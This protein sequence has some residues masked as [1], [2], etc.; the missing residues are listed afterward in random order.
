MEWKPF[1]ALAILALGGVLIVRRWEVRL[2][3]AAVA[4]G[5]HVAAGKVPDFFATLFKEMANPKTILPI[6]SAMGFAYVLK[7][8]ECDRHLVE[9]LVGPLRRVR[10]LLVPGGIAA[11]FIVN[12]AIQSQTGTAAVVGPIL[13]PLLLAGRVKPLTAGAVLLLGSSMGGEL[14]NPG[15][16]EII[17]LANLDQVAQSAVKVV[18]SG[19]LPLNL[20]AC[21]V[22]ALVAWGVAIW[23]DSLIGRRTNGPTPAVAVAAG[24]GPGADAPPRPASESAYPDDPPEPVKALDHTLEYAAAAAG[25]AATGAAAGPFRL[26]VFKALI[27]LLP[28]VLLVAQFIL[29]LP[30]F[31]QTWLGRQAAYPQ[32]IADA[33]NTNFV[34]KA[35]GGAKPPAAPSAPAALPKVMDPTTAATGTAL[36]VG[37]FVAALTSPRRAKRAAVAFF[38]GA[39]FAYNHVV[40]LII[41]ATAVSDGIIQNGLIK[42]AADGLGKHPAGIAALSVLLPWSLATVTGTGIGTA[43]ACIKAIV[44]LAPALHL[45]PVRV[46]ALIAISAQFGRTVSPWAPVVLLCATLSRTGPIDLVKRALPPLLAGGAVLVGAA[47]LLGR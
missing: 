4:L 7:L 3:L 38:D 15:S 10:L 19:V 35:P 31:A 43:V 2:V 45:N 1:T 22:A 30:R 29:T 47:L 42:S 16:V 18:W 37:T 12:A 13:I 17:T 6:C 39:G 5:L 11:A 41:V 23:T 40:S 26:N 33:V 20:L 14:C 8:T 28:I 44:P 36:L 34:P 24:A 9:M 21:G 27:P 46:G 32:A 25:G